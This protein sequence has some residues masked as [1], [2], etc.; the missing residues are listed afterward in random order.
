MLLCP[1]A[2]CILAAVR[3]LFAHNTKKKGDAKMTALM[4]VEVVSAEKSLYDGDAVMVVAPGVAGELGI[5]PRHSP[6][7][8]AIKLGVLR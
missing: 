5:L 2:V 8:T 4:R 6:L 1:V 3:I 7:L